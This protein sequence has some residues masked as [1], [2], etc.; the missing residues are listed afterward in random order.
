MC[1]KI[2]IESP[3]YVRAPKRVQYRRHA[4]MVYG[5]EGTGKTYFALSVMDWLT[6]VQG[7]K[8]EDLMIRIVD[9]DHGI[10]QILDHFN[11]AYYQSIEIAYPRDFQE[12]EDVINWFT[13]ECIEH[14]RKKI[15]EIGEIGVYTAWIICDTIGGWW[16]G[17]TGAQ[18]WYSKAARN[19]SLTE[20]KMD[21]DEKL[22]PRDDY[23]VINPKH[24]YLADRLKA[25]GVNFIWTTPA[26]DVYGEGREKYKKLGKKPAGQKLNTFRV[27]NLVYL[28][29][30]PTKPQNVWSF[31]EKSRDV[32]HFYGGTPDD[33]RGITEEEKLKIITVNRVTYIKHMQALDR[34][35]EI[36]HTD[37]IDA[38]KQMIDGL[39]A[40]KWPNI[41]FSVASIEQVSEVTGRNF[42]L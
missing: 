31:L 17:S 13:N 33:K 24:N 6:L 20:I 19:M 10:E 32:T 38:R 30:D 39:R 5:H 23:K 4:V 29:Q 21:R 25:S 18:E 36:D 16:D 27:D 35:R 22:D 11:E 26:K 3:D 9:T 37:R 28:H 7:L 34:C 12:V 40:K 14:Q 8:A 42:N 1:P 15:A 2:T 41:D